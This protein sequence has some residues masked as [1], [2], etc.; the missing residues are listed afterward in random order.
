MHQ[1]DDGKIPDHLEA[2]L[3]YEAERQG[4]TI[5]EI[6][7]AALEAYLGEPSGRRR[8]GAACAGRRDSSDASQRIEEILAAELGR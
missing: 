5:S 2:L 8:L 6:S 4:V 1:A 7:R 3:R